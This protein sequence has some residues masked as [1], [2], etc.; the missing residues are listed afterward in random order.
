MFW[1]LGLAVIAV[2]TV[3]GA[4]GA[5]TRAYRQLAPLVGAVV[6]IAFTA[7]ASYQQVDAGHVGV[8]REFGAIVGQID[9][10]PNFI[11]PWRE[12][13]EVNVQVQRAQFQVDAASLE[14]QDV[15][16]TVTLNWQVDSREVQRLYR[17]VGPDY[18]AKLVPTR[19]AQFF[20]TEIVKHRSIEATQ[21]REQIRDTVEEA[22]RVELATLSIVV[23]SLQIDNIEYTADFEASIEA[24]Q[25]ASQLALEA[26][27]LVSK[28]EAEA[29]QAVAE[30]EGLANA[31]VARAEGE[32]SARI[33]GAEAEAEA[34]LLEGAAKAQANDLIAASLT[35][36][37]I[38][39]EALKYL[40]DMDIVLLPSGSNF[41]LDPSNILRRQEPASSA[42]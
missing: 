13:Q 11:P 12:S 42:N 41:L 33:L 35:A 18:F 40:P 21:K 34:L 32:K 30:A 22:L 36:D 27:E 1:I 7:F 17:E 37:L 38:Q 15:F 29:R 39:F 14:T 9:E 26:Q 31:Q 23:V 10:G 16:F 3:V 2:G 24:K 19:I 5:P 4:V 25:V 20:K 28:K 6:A 8:V